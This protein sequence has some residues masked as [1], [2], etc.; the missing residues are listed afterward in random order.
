MAIA[1]TEEENPQREYEET[2]S[3]AAVKRR[4]DSES[5]T[6]RQAAKTDLENSLERS[7]ADKKSTSKD[8]MGTSQDISSRH[9]ECDWL[10]TYFT[11]RK[12]A[13]ADEIHSLE[14]AKAVLSGVLRGT[15]RPGG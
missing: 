12:D 14:K 1:E 8:L 9:A 11:V 4:Q 3:E 13:R 6:D 7:I 15:F 2:M 5:L 10:M